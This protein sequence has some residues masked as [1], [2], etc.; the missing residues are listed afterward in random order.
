ML[1]KG[2]LWTNFNIN[3]HIHLWCTFSISK[4]YHETFSTTWNICYVNLSF[5]I[6]KA[7]IIELVQDK[8]HNYI[9]NAARILNLLDTNKILELI[10]K[11]I[12]YKINQWNVKMVWQGMRI[13]IHKA[14]IKNIPPKKTKN[15]KT[16]KLFT[17]SNKNKLQSKSSYVENVYQ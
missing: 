14:S 7:F 12:S 3:K 16:I 5:R 10:Q 4:I 9:K 6:L 1:Q 17:Y 8:S 11:P 2:I 13:Q 15:K